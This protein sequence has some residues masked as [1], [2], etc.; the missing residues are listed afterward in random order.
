MSKLDDIKENVVG[1][2]EEALVK[3]A[4]I[5]DKLPKGSGILDQIQQKIISRK[6]SYTIIPINWKN[7][8]SGNSKFLKTKDKI[9]YFG[10]RY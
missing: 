1:Q 2:V 9:M 3:S 8:K 7:R 5:K 10:F 6:Y 4:E